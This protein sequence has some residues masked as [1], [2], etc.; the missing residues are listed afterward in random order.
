VP[1]ANGRSYQPNPSSYV[2]RQHLLYFRF[3]GRIIARA[4]IEGVHV[5]AHLSTAFCKNLLQMPL[6]VRDVEPVDASLHRS[7][8]W[9][10]ENDADGLE[11]KF[12]ADFDD[13]G[14]HREIPLKEGGERMDVTNENKAEFV[15]L[16]TELRLK[17]QVQE[18]LKEFC[19]GFYSLIPL[20]EIRRFTPNELDLLICGVP[21][22]DVDDLMANCSYNHPYGPNTKVV[23][24]FFK[25]VKGW[26]NENLAKLLLFITGSSHVPMTGFKAFRDIGQPI[27]LSPGGPKERLPVAHTCANTLDLPAY[28]NEEELE[29]KLMFAIQECDTFEL[30]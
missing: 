22:I 4:L 17:K 3:A 9:I 24:L 7:L 5:D 16:M 21:E 18:Q 12:V 28:G 8:M 27:T 20:E 11:M 30:W 15:G 26:T 1:S 13:V 6:S 23:K 25:V 19:E 2:N 29:A 10:M 14:V